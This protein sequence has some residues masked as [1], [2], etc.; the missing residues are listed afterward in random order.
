MGSGALGD[1]GRGWRLPR[2]DVRTAPWSTAIA[3]TAASAI[4]RLAM[5]AVVPVFPDESYYWEWSRHLAA[6]YFDHP[7]VIAF[8]IR[9]GTGALG[10]TPLGV[11]FG[12]WLAGSLGIA[13]IVLLARDLGGPR[14]AVWTSL[15]A[16]SMPMVTLGLVLATPDAP[17]VFF[18]A[19][20]LLA[21]E[22]AVARPAGSTASRW[23]WLLAGVSS[24][25]AFLSKYP[26]VLLPASV[27]LAFVIRRDLRPQ[28]RRWEPYAAG[29][30]AAIVASPVVV[31]NARHD[32]VSFRF[33]LAHGLGARAAP[34]VVLAMSAIGGRELTLAGGA[35]LMASPLFLVLAVAAVRRG[36]RG[37]APPGGTLLAIVATAWAGVFI[38]GAARHSSEANWLAPAFLAAVPL[39]GAAL[40][41]R[42]DPWTFGRRLMIPA[43][44]VGLAL[45]AASCAIALVPLRAIPAP[46]DPAARARGWSQVAA[47][48]ASV[49]D[50]I[51]HGPESGGAR[52]RIAANTYQDASE[53]A[54]ALP[55]HPTVF[56]LNILSRRN[57]YDLWPGFVA[58]ARPGDALLV[59]LNDDAGGGQVR[60]RIAAAFTRVADAGPVERTREATGGDV[61]ARRHLWIFAGW[62]GVPL[63]R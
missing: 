56:A 44:A 25:A 41:Q 2:I 60:D 58:A 63:L 12:A 43:A 54:F 22:R 48:V 21:V 50:S 6:G 49:A 4:A 42:N 10:A 53:L 28:L 9:A 40:V 62:R 34:G 45:G 18:L 23:W 33:Q 15:A 51:S 7:P 1:L 47:R 59:V 24:G 14:A 39:I 46:R 8:L 11:R 37:T 29:A 57:Q 36:L 30:V 38:A 55:G 31:W 52:V 19:L 20:A 3:L 27:A 13:L 5:A 17:L 35:A 26:A 61:I 32:W 16:A